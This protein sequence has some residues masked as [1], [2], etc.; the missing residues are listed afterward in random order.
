[1]VTH[2]WLYS[3]AGRFLFPILKSLWDRCLLC[4]LYMQVCILFFCSVDGLPIICVCG[5]CL[6]F[7]E[8]EFREGHHCGRIIMKIQNPDWPGLSICHCCLFVPYSLF[9]SSA[10][11]HFLPLVNVFFT[12]AHYFDYIWQ[13]SWISSSSRFGFFLF[14]KKEG[15]VG[16]TKI[17]IASRSSQL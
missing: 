17:W 14:I 1:M 7:A 3:Y 5:L 8:G 9:F 15:L 4:Y 6:M 13:S 2:I 16:V 11:I 10:F 12:L